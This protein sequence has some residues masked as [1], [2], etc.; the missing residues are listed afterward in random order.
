MVTSHLGT[1]S[2]QPEAICFDADA[3]TAPSSLRLLHGDAQHFVLGTRGE[4]TRK[5]VDS[6]VLPAPQWPDAAPSI[7]S[8]RPSECDRAGKLG[9]LNCPA[10]CSRCAD[11]HAIPPG[12]PGFDRCAKRS[13]PYG[14]G[15]AGDGEA[16]PPRNYRSWT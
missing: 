8:R 9:E 1:Q 14:R 16:S 7:T 4:K 15:P 3:D 13:G 2:T 10:W 11:G 5:V 6:P 12:P